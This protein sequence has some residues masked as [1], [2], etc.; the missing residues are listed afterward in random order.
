MMNKI[1]IIDNQTCRRYFK[2]CYILP[3]PVSASVAQKLTLLG[4]AELPITVGNF[5]LQHVY[6]EAG[7]ALKFSTGDTHIFLSIPRKDEN[8]HIL[9]SL[10]KTLWNVLQEV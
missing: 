4:E 8:Y 6:L 1:K 2:R 5:I 9:G 7:A 3:S 10:E